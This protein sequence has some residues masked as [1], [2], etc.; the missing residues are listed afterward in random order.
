MWEPKNEESVPI[1]AI[2]GSCLDMKVLCVAGRGSYTAKWHFKP[3]HVL[4]RAVHMPCRHSLKTYRY[5]SFLVAGTYL[6][7]THL[8]YCYGGGKTSPFYLTPSKTHSGKW[9]I[10]VQFHTQAKQTQTHLFCHPGILSYAARLRG[11][12]VNNFRNTYCSSFHHFN[13]V[14]G[15]TLQ[16]Q[17]S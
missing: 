7:R 1:K 14:M 15:M 12:I 17:A 6:H 11:K 4:N 5:K 9:L 8:L 2:P 10:W 13:L 16:W 3:S